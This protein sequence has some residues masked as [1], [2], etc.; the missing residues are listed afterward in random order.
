MPDPCPTEGT[1]SHQALRTQGD[2]TEDL[3]KE[4]AERQ[5]PSYGPSAFPIVPMESPVMLGPHQACPPQTTTRALHFAGPAL[6]GRKLH[7]V[8]ISLCALGHLIGDPHPP[9][10]ISLNKFI[11]LSPPRTMASEAVS[12]LLREPSHQKVQEKQAPTES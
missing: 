5:Y 11:R 3:T 9:E 7:A 2:L 6:P 10:C 8:F 1:H 12:S 4:T